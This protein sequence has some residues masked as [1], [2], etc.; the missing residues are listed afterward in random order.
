M[1]P[2][3]NFRFRR[4]RLDTAAGA[5]YHTKVSY[6]HNTVTD[7]TL[8]KD[9]QSRFVPDEAKYTGGLDARQGRQRRMA[10]I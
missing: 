3:P 10:R 6:E 1:E 4:L 9:L 7:Q 8:S 5:W 2:R